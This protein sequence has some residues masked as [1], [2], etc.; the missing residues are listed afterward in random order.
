LGEIELTRYRAL[1]AMLR[2]PSLAF[3]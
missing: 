3:T 1:E 2:D